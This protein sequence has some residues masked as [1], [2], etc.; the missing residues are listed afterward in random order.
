MSSKKYNWDE[1][2]SN[3]Q[4]SNLSQAEFCRQN[5]LNAKYLSLQ[6]RKR[7]LTN[8]RSTKNKTKSPFIKTVKKTQTPTSTKVIIECRSTKIHINQP[9]SKWLA[10]FCK[11]M[12]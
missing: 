1:I 4:R 12:G 5:Q 11:A 7:N 10:D 9:D 2:I 6:L 8:S 3:F